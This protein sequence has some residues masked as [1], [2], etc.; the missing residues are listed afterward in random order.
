M[1]KL[2]F[3][4]YSKINLGL[5]V[6]N[7]RSDGFHNIN[8]IFIQTDFSDRL[9]FKKSNFFQLSCDN[10]K[11]PIDRTNTIA[12]AY[13][14]LNQQFKFK[15]HYK[16]HLNKNIPIGAGLGGG[17]SNAAC[18]LLS[19]TNLLNLNISSKS[20][21][22][23]ALDIG[24]DVP[25]FLNGG[26]KFVEGR[27]EIIKSF[28]NSDIFQNLYILL[29]FP[30]FSIS[31]KWAYENLKLKKALKSNNKEHKFSPL[32]DRVNW[33]LF[34][35]DF[36]LIVKEAYP[37]IMN[38]KDIMNNNGALYSSLSGTGSTVFGIYNEEKFILKTQ[39][40]LSHYKTYRASP[41]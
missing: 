41:I 23:I 19:L 22:K 16:I 32:D 37:E 35:N 28:K 20:L 1:Y 36:E 26:I 17:S 14:I 18:T 6:L 3:E 30:A 2:N 34:E 38:I 31:T 5:K 25:F 4:S 29:V 10:S 9:F 21:Y 7:K 33:K 24:S 13:Q 40:K 27:G 12:K 15:N 11:V 39:S 8:S